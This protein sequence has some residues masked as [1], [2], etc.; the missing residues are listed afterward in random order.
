[1]QLWTIATWIGYTLFRLFSYNMNIAS[2]PVLFDWFVCEFLSFFVRK[3]PVPPH[4][5]PQTPG[6]FIYDC[7]LYS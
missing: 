6:N 4:P 2:T 1:M 5:T 7:N 3:F